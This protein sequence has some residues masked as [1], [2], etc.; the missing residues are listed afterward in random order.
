MVAA[1]LAAFMSTI[2]TQL[3]WGTSYLVNDFYRRFLVKRATEHHYVNVGKIFTVVLVLA[4]GYVSSRLASIS[5]G[6]QIVLGIGAGT[7]GVLILRWYWWRIN[8]WSEIVATIAAAVLTFVLAEMKLAG[9]GAVVTAKTTLITAAVTTVLWLV[10]TVV[11]K[12]EPAEKLVAFYR[13][14][15]P[16]VYGWQPIAK[17]CPEMPQV[18]D[19]VTN[20]TNWVVGCVMVYAALFGIGNLVFH[21]FLLGI[22]LLGLSAL[23]GWIIFSN[24]SRQG[25]GTLSGAAD[26]AAIARM[27]TEKT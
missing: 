22:L 8:A 5:E 16:S 2:G 21:R 6:W 26:A 19:F 3:N 1:F 12:P 13:R 10:G 25:W 27:A 24:L 9:S 17:M 11:T 23:S 18:R 4:G 20:F 15:H 7:G 14:V